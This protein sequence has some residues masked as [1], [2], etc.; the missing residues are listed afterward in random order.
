[1]PGAPITETAVFSPVVTAP[2]DGDAANGASIVAGLQPLANR[3]AYLNSSQTTLAAVVTALLT[4]LNNSNII[5]QIRTR[6]GSGGLAAALANIITSTG[7]TDLP[8]S[9]LTVGPCDSGDE[10]HV[11][12]TGTLFGGGVVGSDTSAPRARIVVSSAS[13]A[14][15]LASPSAEAQVTLRTPGTF[16]PICCSGKHTVNY[17]ET[18]TVKVQLADA[19]SGAASLTDSWQLS[20]KRVDLGP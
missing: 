3:T 9:S 8:G 20:V 11:D 15:V 16:A 13:Q 1:M 18:Y 17:G 6:S 2:V 10:L 14:L 19:A 5:R 12:F 7:Y 4:T